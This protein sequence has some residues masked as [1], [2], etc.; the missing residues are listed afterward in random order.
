MPPLCSCD[1][2]S[3]LHV[4]TFVPDKRK[5]L[6]AGLSLC[7]C[8]GACVCVKPTHYVE[9]SHSVFDAAAV[10]SHTCVL[11]RVVSGDVSYY[12]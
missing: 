5:P 4:G 8:G 6:E 3:P 1:C 9:L 10:P 7:A 12:Q 2:G 11:T